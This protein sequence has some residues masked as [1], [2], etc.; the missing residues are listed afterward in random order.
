MFFQG[1][2]RADDLVDILLLVI[3]RDDDNTVAFVHNLMID[4][5]KVRK[6]YDKRAVIALFLVILHTISNEY[7]RIRKELR[8]VAADV[9]SGK[10]VGKIFSEDDFPRRLI[11]LFG[12]DVVW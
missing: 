5:A 4:G 8:T 1:E 3:G 12:P 11:G 10:G 2:Y 7:T 9:G 6:I